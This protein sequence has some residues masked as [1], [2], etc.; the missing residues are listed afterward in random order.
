MFSFKDYYFLI[1][2]QN[3]IISFILFTFLPARNIYI[4]M[5]Y[6]YYRIYKYNLFN[7]FDIICMCMITDLTTWY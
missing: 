6:V 3:V 2:N 5:K 1:L 4:D 7:P